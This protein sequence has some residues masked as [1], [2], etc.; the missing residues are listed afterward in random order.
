MTLEYVSETTKNVE[1]SFAFGFALHTRVFDELTL[2]KNVLKNYKTSF[3]E[4]SLF[5]V[6]EWKK[7]RSDRPQDKFVQY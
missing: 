6:F 2:K 1:S 7:Q 3:Y 4:S 5:N